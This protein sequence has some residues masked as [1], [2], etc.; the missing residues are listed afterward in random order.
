[1][2]DGA[3]VAVSLRI[4]G[5]ATVSGLYWF[6]WRLR[7][8]VIALVFKFEAIYM[9]ESIPFFVEQTHVIYEMMTLQNTFERG[10]VIF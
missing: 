3:S 4:V 5:Y 6:W 1:M 10:S 8:F 2:R 9:Y 7:S